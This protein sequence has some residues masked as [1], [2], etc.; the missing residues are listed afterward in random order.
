MRFQLGKSRLSV[1]VFLSEDET[2]SFFLRV[3]ASAQGWREF[4]CA[5]VWKLRLK[6]RRTEKKFF[7]TIKVS[8][9][10]NAAD[11]PHA[12]QEI[13]SKKRFLIL[14][15]P[16]SKLM[17][18]VSGIG[19]EIGRH[20]PVQIELHADRGTT[21]PSFAV[22]AS[23]LGYKPEAQQGKAGFSL[24]LLCS[25]HARYA[26]PTR[27]KATQKE[28]FMPLYLDEIWLNE[29]SADNVK[30]IHK[31]FQSVLSGET[32]F[33]E[34]VSL[35]AGPW[36]SNE[37]AKIILILDIQDHAKT[38]VTFS[39]VMASGLVLKRKLTPIV[40]WKAMDDVVK[41]L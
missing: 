36:A 21:A 33:P 27:E 41:A 17:L 37:E 24:S 1:C 22:R 14:L 12:P 2:P 40:D 13:R 28:G 3:D 15:R 25:S 11:K 19:H 31:M 29:T 30:K 4:N 32:G 5:L 34:G 8:L 38:F 16:L 18:V 39:T 9:A 23:W 10:F 35:K 20:V 7:R 26:M 6:Q